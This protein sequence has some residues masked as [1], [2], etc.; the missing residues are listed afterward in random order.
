MEALVDLEMGDDADDGEE[1]E[2]GN[3]EGE[4]KKEQFIPKRSTL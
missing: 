2:L 3:H 4:E 1:R